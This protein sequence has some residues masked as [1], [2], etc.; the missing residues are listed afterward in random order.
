[1]PKCHHGPATQRV[2]GGQMVELELRGWTP[3]QREGLSFLL[4]DAQIPAEWG[5]SSVSVPEASRDQAQRFI[6]FLADTSGD[7]RF[8]HADPPARNDAAW[9][10]DAAHPHRSPKTSASRGRDAGTPARRHAHRRRTALPRRW[11]R[12]RAER[13]QR[14]SGTRSML[15]A[16]LPDRHGRAARPDGRQHGCAHPGRLRRRPRRPGRAGR[17]HPLARPPGRMADRARP[18]LARSAQLPLVA[19]R[20]HPGARRPELPRAARPGRRA[21]SSSTTG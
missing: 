14:A 16:V 21:S 15:V 3:T 10:L 4:D 13:Q 12:P 7:I 9:I 18:V 1:M 11:P 17:L 19:R 8:E 5:P 20:L 6:D 2:Q